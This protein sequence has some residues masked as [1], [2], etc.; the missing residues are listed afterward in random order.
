M[1]LVTM[2]VA[3]R[4]INVGTRGIVGEPLLVVLDLLGVSERQVS[5]QEVIPS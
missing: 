4:P 5:F 2:A 3:I 1:T